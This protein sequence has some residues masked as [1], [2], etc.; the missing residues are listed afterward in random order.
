M[1]YLNY[2]QEDAIN[3]GIGYPTSRYSR[4]AVVDNNTIGYILFQER[5]LNVPKCFIDNTED[6]DARHYYEN[7]NNANSLLLRK[8]YFSEEQRYDGVLENLFDY[9]VNEILPNDCLIWCNNTYLLRDY[10]EQIGGF[11]TP[12]HVLPNKL[13]R[14]FSIN[15]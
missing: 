10:I 5:K 14:L 15:L 6:E 11:N 4:K 7:L 13:I 3:D 8:I 12:L 2:T 9:I 1:E